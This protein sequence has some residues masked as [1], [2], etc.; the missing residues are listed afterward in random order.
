M[1]H[2]V[3]LLGLYN[4]HTIVNHYTTRNNIQEFINKARDTT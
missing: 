3:S 4:K 1:K 2:D